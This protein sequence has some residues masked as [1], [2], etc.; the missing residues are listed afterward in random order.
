MLL[1]YSVMIV[2]DEPM[3]RK[4]LETLVRKSG[5]PFSL[6]RTMCNGEEALDAIQK[7]CPDFLFTDIRMPKMDG[8]ELSR[9][10]SERFPSVQITV[11]SGYSEFEYARQCVA[12]G[13]KEYMLKPMN[14][15]NVNA[16]LN[17]LIA[18]KSKA[19][20]PQFSPARMEALIDR[21][22]KAIWELD[23]VYMD[24]LLKEWRTEYM[25]WNLDRARRFE[26]L[27]E[28]YSILVK[29][30]KTLGIH[31]VEPEL[32]LDFT[33][34][35]E[36]AYAKFSERIREIMNDLA[37]L[38]KGSFMN[39][40]TEVKRLLNENLSKDI[41]LDEIAE[42]VGLNASYLSSL[43]KQETGET[44]VQYRI[45]KRMER[46]KQLL[47]IPHYRITEVS[48]EVGYADHPHFTKTFKKYTGLTPSEYREMLGIK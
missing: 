22:G 42:K 11:V 33:L 19:A 32:Q 6:I 12:Y 26:L 13:V 34:N 3:I 16:I 2:D 40:V 43:F 24:Q 20:S 4:G 14:Q 10:V 8:L 46:A 17:K 37:K 1:M 44:F 5:Y 30:L 39:P 38:R 7:E 21:S 47:S 27:Q 35:L 28:F 36:Q 41:S 45:R 48:F 31:S 18:G 29:R 23:F 9:I 15:R 25:R